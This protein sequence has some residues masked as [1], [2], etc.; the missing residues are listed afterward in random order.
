MQLVAGNYTLYLILLNYNNYGFIII[1]HLI[2]H[3][4]HLFVRFVYDYASSTLSGRQSTCGRLLTPR[5]AYVSV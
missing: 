1:S 4:F 3:I 5:D 2:F